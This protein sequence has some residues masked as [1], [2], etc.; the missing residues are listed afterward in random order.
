MCGVAGSVADIGWR[1]HCLLAREPVSPSAD[2]AIRGI[3]IRVD[4]ADYVG[5]GSMRFGV[6]DFFSYA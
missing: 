4:L 5:V 3:F 2:T 1:G 6:G